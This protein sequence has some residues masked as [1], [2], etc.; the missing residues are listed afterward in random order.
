MTARLVQ[1]VSFHLP[2]QVC[3]H[4]RHIIGAWLASELRDAL[5]SWLTSIPSLN[6]KGRLNQAAF[7]VAQ[8]QAIGIG[9]GRRRR[10]Q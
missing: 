9:R 8:K 1:A 4:Q 2:V 3:D 7:F 10:Q 5:L 6:R